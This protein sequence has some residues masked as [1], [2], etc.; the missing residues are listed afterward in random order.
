MKGFA[1][2]AVLYLAL[3]NI[4]FLVTW[5][6]PWIGLPCALIVVYC[7]AKVI[8]SFEDAPPQNFDRTTK[9]FIFCLA[10][11]WTVI[12]GAAACFPNARA[13]II[14][15]HNLL[16]HDLI[17]RNWP[18]F[19]M[20]RAT[21]NPSSV[22]P[23][24]TTLCRRWSRAAWE[25]AGFPSRR[26]CGR[27]LGSGFF[28]AGLPISIEKLPHGRS[29]SFFSCQHWNSLVLCQELGRAHA[30]GG[31]RPR[32]SNP[33]W[34]TK[35]SFA[36]SA[37][38]GGWLGS[39][40]F[41]DMIWLRRKPA[42]TMFIWALIL[43]WSPF[44]PLGLLLVPLLALRTMEVRSYLESINLVGGGVMILVL[45]IYYKAHATLQDSGWIWTHHTS[46][47]W[48]VLYLLFI[49]MQVLLP[50]AGI[51]LVDHKYD[52]L[53]NLRPLFLGATLLLLLLP[54]YKVGH[55][56][57]LRLQVSGLF[58]FSCPWARRPVLPAA[59]L[60]GATLFS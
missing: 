51:L 59:I 40:L 41:Y 45:G 16:F 28:S 17:N 29:S 25:K 24:A 22:I 1:S 11:F 8:I 15:R 19:M 38:P 12:S 47:N 31:V 27:S 37:Y 2:L 54:L 13:K 58:W 48:F 7:C 52:I 44:S 10:L 42:G 46:V 23:S 32:F 30:I 56:N 50:V 21:G 39:A 14:S 60:V 20:T 3:P 43:F 9:L 4:L 6:N 57:D 34:W 35:I 33:D 53:Q 55:F 18:C 26:F 49:I 5:L 36:A